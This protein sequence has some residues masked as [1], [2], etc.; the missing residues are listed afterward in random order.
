[1]T[2]KKDTTT[3]EEKTAFRHAEVEGLPVLLHRRMSPVDEVDLLLEP[4]G[5]FI[6]A[7]V[8]TPRG[9]A[10]RVKDS[11]GFDKTFT[12]S[13]VEHWVEHA[14]GGRSIARPIPAVDLPRLA[15]DLDENALIAVEVWLRALY[16][17]DALCH[18]DDSGASVMSHGEKLFTIEAAKVYDADADRAHEEPVDLYDLVGRIVDEGDGTASGEEANRRIFGIDAK[19]SAKTPRPLGVHSGEIATTLKALVDESFFDAFEA[20]Y[21]QDLGP[22]YDLDVRVEK[23]LS[24]G[25]DLVITIGDLEFWVVVQRSK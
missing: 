2:T 17:V 13:A 25:H 22:H 9:L 3:F 21:G 12:R 6:V 1:M 18:P 19:A 23:R 4:T 11:I 8:E 20:I 7:H 24:Q 10:P 15:P 14:Y 16:E 5:G